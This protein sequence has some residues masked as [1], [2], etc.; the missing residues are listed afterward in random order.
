MRFLGNFFFFCL[1]N[2]T[3]RE[4]KKKKGRKKKKESEREAGERTTVYSCYNASENKN[5]LKNV[6]II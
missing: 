2:F 6:A 5:Q 3:R 1:V 4:K